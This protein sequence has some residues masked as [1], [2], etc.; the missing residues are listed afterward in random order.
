MINVSFEKKQGYLH[1]M[2]CDNGV[3]LPENYNEKSS[4]GMTVIEALAEQLEAKF[5]FTQHTGTC[6][7]M[8]FKA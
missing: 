3:G 8:S 6:F 2:V 1:L 4:L 7:K 5:E